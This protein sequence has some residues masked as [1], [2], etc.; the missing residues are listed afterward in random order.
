MKC[1]CSKSSNINKTFICILFAAI[2]SNMLFAGNYVSTQ[3][4]DGYFELA[5]NGKSAPLYVS[6]EDYP[7]VNKI[8]T[9]FQND[10]KLVSGTQPEI[11][12]SLPDA[13]EIIII[14]T[15]GKSPVIDNLVT[16]KKLDISSIKG[17]WETFQIQVLENPYPSVKKALVIAGSDKRGTIFGMF[18][19]SREIGVSP[20]YW[21]ADAPP[22]KKSAIY[23][24]PGMHSKG[25][26]KVKYRG[27]FIN[28]EAPALTGWVG[29][30]YGGFNHKFYEKVFELILRLQGNYLWPAMWGRS[31]YDDDSLSA[32]L[33][34]EMGVVIG[35]SHHEPLMRAHVEW[36]RYGKGDWN[37]ET[38]PEELQKFW[39]KGLERM[40]ENESIVT[41]GMRGDG[42][43][44]M[45]EGTVIE[46]LE[47]IVNDQRKIIE[48]VTGMPVHETPQ[49]WALYKEV[50]DYYDKG[51]RVPEDVILLLCDDNWGNVRVLPK[52]EDWDR[53]GGFGIYYHYDF[54]GGPVSY[55]WLN[56]TQIEKVWEQMNLSYQWAAKE[57]WLVN[58]GDIKPMELPISFFL[59]FAWDP[60]ALTADKL[61]AYYTYWAR[62]QFGE[63][64]AVEIGEILALYTKYNARRT[65]E[66]LKPDTYSLHNYREAET[67]VNDYNAL[68]QR[69]SKIYDL[70]PEETKAAYFQLVQFPVEI[71]A[72]LNEL[73]VSAAKNKFYMDQGRASTNYYA[74]KVK[75]LFVKDS[76]LTNYF[77][78]DLLDG[79][80]NYIMSQ[81]HIG[82]TYWNQPPKN[83]M[84]SVMEHIPSKNAKLGIWIEEAK[85]DGDGSLP[86]FDSVNKQQF[87]VE[88]F[89][90]GLQ[91]L[92]YSITPKEEWIKVSKLKGSVTYE[93]RVYISIDWNK[94]PDEKNNG[95][96]K[97][98]G[99]DDVF[100]VKVQAVKNSK[101]VHGFV[102]NNGVISIEAANFNNAVTSDHVDWVVVPNMG[103][104]NSAVQ[105]HPVNFDPFALGDESPRL[106]YEFT[107][108]D[109]GE[110][111]I[112]VY[113]S[114]TLNFKKEE[115]LKYAV[116]VDNEKPQ[117]I[118][119]HEGETQPDWAYPQWWNQSVTDHIK[120]KSS[121]HVILEDGKHTLKIW[122]VDPGVVFQKIVIDKGGLKTSYLGPPQ[123]MNVK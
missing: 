36:D 33:A 83:T 8:L 64:H 27:I 52:K 82:Y 122:A 77:H 40:G 54:V 118:N 30:N 24:K 16:D 87:F 120:I 119:M 43:E 25:T 21:W 46:L 111:D 108:F 31:I 23:I 7:G 110:L 26:P 80:W 48:E 115:G 103:R 92:E 66:M 28:D 121:K 12:N 39:R 73:Y 100:N 60:E 88:I 72:N 4:Q 5:A 15:I 68:A 97:I 47:K 101:K 95:S 99:A 74:Q 41:I 20:W 45:T 50:Q 113:L 71:C 42:D 84:P 63:K 56:V 13:R 61:P 67:I 94:I 35:T 70:L 123:S 89:N 107:V 117:I 32:P 2:F 34:N 75:E 93:E 55:K 85:K 102:E 10:I 78:K 57:L 9:L 104:T 58:V 106:E 96:V 62:Q 98:S 114:P 59:D 22:Q 79:K 1:D 17:K 81:T 11:F 3:M 90:K 29:D 116:S 49:A 86:Q 112:Q 53:K 91:P 76:T 6:P 51:M 65:P 37:Y 19:I 44:A 69:S 14:G 38:N 105:L 18:D 109:K